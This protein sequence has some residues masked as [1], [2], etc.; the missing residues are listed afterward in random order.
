MSKS[1][2]NGFQVDEM[3]ARVGADAARTTVLSLG[4]WDTNVNWSDGALAGVQRFLKRVENMA[5]NLTDEPMSAEQ[6]RLVHQL[7]AD[8]TDRLENM[9]FNTA[10]SAMMEFINQFDGKMPR[11]A[12]D[13][14]IQ[15][16]NPFA[17][18]MT[19]EIWQRMGHSEML[20]FQPWPTY[21]VSKLAKMSMTIVASVNGKR[22]AE[23]I[24][25]VSASETDIIS[26]AR[27]AAAKNWLGPTLLKQL[28]YQINWLTLL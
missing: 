9:R 6:E 17:P 7:I 8:M 20:V 5:D 19:E 10:I 28:L 21:D 23:F 14:L 13:V 15:M 27:D 1:A 25:P 11:P 2:G 26:A 4:P 12:Y 16:L 18:H 3:V 22:A 24:V